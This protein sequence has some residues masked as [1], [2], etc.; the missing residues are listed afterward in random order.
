MA[1]STKPGGKYDTEN[2]Q[3]VSYGS[4][5]AKIESEAKEY[6]RNTN[7]QASHKQDG[8]MIV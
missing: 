3:Y 7:C 6:A 4:S 8:K 1:I 5:N 2:G